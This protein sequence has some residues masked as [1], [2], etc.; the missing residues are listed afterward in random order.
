M[1]NLNCTPPTEITTHSA[2][3]GGTADFIPANHFLRIAYG[4]TN[5]GPFNTFTT[6]DPGTNSP[7]QVYSTTLNTLLPNQQYYYVLQEL[8]TDGVTI[9]AESDQCAFHT[10]DYETRCTVIA[11]DETSV[12]VQVCA[13][14]VAPDQTL[15]FIYGSTPGGPYPNVGGSVPGQDIK[16]QC[17]V[18]TLPLAPCQIIYYRGSVT[19]VPAIYEVDWQYAHRARSNGQETAQLR[20]GPEALYPGGQT[21]V[22]THT[23]NGAAEGWTVRNGTYPVPLNINTLHMGFVAT[24]PPGSVGNFLDSCS[25]ILRRVLPSPL[26]IGEQLQNPDFEIPAMAPNSLVFWPEGGGTPGLVWE[27]T[28]PVPVIEMWSN[29]F[30]GVTANTGT[31]FV[32]LNAFNPAE[33]FQVVPL[34]VATADSQECVASTFNLDCDSA[35][36][37]ECTTA[38][39]HGRYCGLPEGYS[40]QFQYATSIGGP[41]FDAGPANFVAVR[42]SADIPISLG[43]TS[44]TPGTQYFYRLVAKDTLQ[45]IIGT[46]ETCDFT[47]D[48]C[49]TWCGG[50][51]DPQDCTLVD[52]PNDDYFNCNPV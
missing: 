43:A 26:V 38:T 4:V 34:D 44:L 47:T 8:D 11:F 21:L 30:Q 22:D 40:V 1:A 19:N 16:D 14:F 12:T 35:T 52:T 28:D 15:D 37:V 27:T 50:W 39:L 36:E 7:G 29:A 5:G 9:L 41:Y 33:L 3:V 45:H 10:R 42:S 49:I 17:A 24:A 6:P 25:I 18:F 20:I 2:D 51:H 23:A 32:E 48:T 46:S 13:D 31:Q